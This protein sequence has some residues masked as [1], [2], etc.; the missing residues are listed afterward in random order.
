MSQ[1]ANKQNEQKIKLETEMQIL[2]KCMED[3]KAIYT[4]NEEKLKFNY[5]VLYEREGVNKKTMKT[6]NNRKRRAK[7]TLSEVTK[8]FR[9]QSSKFQ[10]Q[11][12]NLTNE[13]KQFTA[14]F[15]DLQKKYERFEKSDD[16]RIKE[17]WSM[18]DQEARNLA[19]KIMHADKVIHLQQLSIAWKPPSDPFFS[20][21]SESN[22]TANDSSYKGADSAT[23]GNSQMNQNTSI[24]DSQ[25]GNQQAQSKSELVDDQSVVTGNAHDI[26]DKYEKIK[27]VFK[28]LI[29]ECPYLIDDKAI[30]KCEG[31]NL[32][33]QFS[34][35]IDSIRKSLGIEAM[36]DVELLVD[37]LYSYQAYSDKMAVE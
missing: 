18:N 4:L 35:K 22:A 30:E 19:E 20:F 5:E 9:I 14:W 10:K 6:L 26:R 2:E 29:V 8:Q 7:I 32:K 15:K 37:T 1:D 25:G 28:M 17:V 31:Q 36:Q 24:M 11:N 34:I 21:L 27:N 13:Y 12:I 33:S 23:Q 16:N 3:M